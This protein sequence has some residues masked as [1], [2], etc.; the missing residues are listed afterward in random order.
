MDI[1]ASLASLKVSLPTNNVQRFK[2]VNNL[3]QA[4]PQQLSNKTYRNAL[5]SSNIFI[6]AVQ[7]YNDLSRAKNTPEIKTAQDIRDTLKT[8]KFTSL[9][10]ILKSRTTVHISDLSARL[11]GTALDQKG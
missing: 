11:R 10:D 8:S 4:D 9:N 5:V 3:L 7:L 1:R 6:K 2:G